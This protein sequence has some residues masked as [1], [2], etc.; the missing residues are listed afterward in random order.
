MVS[1]LTLSTEVFIASLA[2]FACCL[3]LFAAP[4]SAP[5]N[6]PRAPPIA[7]P[8]G[9][10][11]IPPTAAPPTPPA[12]A[13]VPAPLALAALPRPAIARPAI[14]LYIPTIPPRASAPCISCGA[15]WEII[16]RPMP[17]PIFAPMLFA[18]PPIPSSLFP[19]SAVPPAVPR[20]ARN[21][22]PGVSRFSARP[23]VWL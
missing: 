11:I 3:N 18:A 5:P 1:R 19:R 14:G 13:P 16:E 12:S 20:K 17:T 15:R 23:V 10:A 2:S 21:L 6:A 9:P 7:A 22:I 4:I 8:T